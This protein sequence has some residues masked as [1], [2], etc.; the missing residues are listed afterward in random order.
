MHD[1]A[2]GCYRCAAPAEGQRG[3]SG[4]SGGRMWQGK[5]CSSL[6]AAP[7]SPVMSAMLTASVS[8]PS[9]LFSVSA[10]PLLLP[11]SSDGTPP[12]T[13][14]IPAMQVLNN[15]LLAPGKEWHLLCLLEH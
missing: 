11:A 15:S 12:S 4:G 13:S 3:R 2:A 10:S 6:S 8:L 5:L 9:L 14:S 1:S 7:K